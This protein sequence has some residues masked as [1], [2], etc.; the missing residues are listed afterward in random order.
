V[1]A[2]DCADENALL[3]YVDGLAPA[4]AR[5]RIANHLASCAA[6]RSLLAAI[7]R[8]DRPRADRANTTPVAILREHLAADAPWREIIAVKWALALDTLSLLGAIGTAIGHAFGPPIPL[9]VAL[10]AYHIPLFIALR[11]GWYHP[12]VAF[13]NGVLEVSMPFAVSLA[14]GIQAGAYAAWAHPGHVLWGG[15]V[16]F[17]SI[18][19]DRRIGWVVGT[20]A[21]AEALALYAIL[22]V[23]GPS[24]LSGDAHAW[25]ILRAVFLLMCGVGGGALSR[26]LIARV[27]SALRAAREQDLMSKYVLHE[28]LGVGGMAEVYRATYCPEGG[29]AKTVAVKRVLPALAADPHFVDAIREEARLG[30]ML[31]HPNVVQVLDCGRYRDKF[32]LAMEHVDGVALATLI[33]RSGALSPAIVAFLGSELATAL[34]YIHHRRGADGQ[35]LGLVHCDV[36]PPNVLVSRHGEVKL[37]DFGVARATARGPSDWV[38]GKQAY[39]APEQVAHAPLDARTDLFAL[40]L[41][42]HEALIGARRW[43]NVVSDA[44]IP[45]VSL[46]RN[47]VP[48]KLDAIIDELV[49]L[50]AEQRPSSAAEIGRRLRELTEPGAAVALGEI[51]AA[52]LAGGGR[53]PATFAEASTVRS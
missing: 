40:G 48:A 41:T 31:A 24:A 33:K 5:T 27:E 22:E 14:F 23:R 37:G 21:A 50:S 44:P 15:F 25:A 38:G 52:A 13:A 29:F 7:G 26:V 32:L 3:E 18:R 47:D 1:D 6:C 35:P 10:L 16:V 19:F 36:N 2:S 49:A 43:G 34:D 28:R 20:L 9:P 51:V 17:A 8:E 45:R 53:A 12:A 30:A 46:F 39:A 42:L 4:D 11:R